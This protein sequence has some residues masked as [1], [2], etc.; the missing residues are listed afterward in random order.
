MLTEVNRILDELDTEH[1]SRRLMEEL[2]RSTREQRNRFPA[3]RK[4]RR[5]VRGDRSGQLST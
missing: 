2:D 5:R 4:L 3:L 1:R